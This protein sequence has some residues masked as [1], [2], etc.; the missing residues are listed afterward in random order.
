V[1]ERRNEIPHRFPSAASFEE[2][3]G[4]RDHDRPVEHLWIAFEGVLSGFERAGQGGVIVLPELGEEALV[5]RLL[6]LMVIED[7]LPARGAD[8]PVAV[9][10]QAETPERVEDRD[11]RRFGHQ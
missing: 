1:I 3:L 8:Q 7:V 2:V 9:F 11:S 10:H 5:E 6:D 4:Q